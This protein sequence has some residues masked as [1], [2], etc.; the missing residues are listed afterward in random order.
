MRIAKTYKGG[1]A[2][3]EALESDIEI[4]PSW[5]T[6][7]LAHIRIEGSNGRWTDARLSAIRKRGRI[8]FVLSHEKGYPSE[9]KGQVTRSLT[10]NWIKKE[11]PK[12]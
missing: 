6:T 9:N 12:I 4:Y 3:V 8:R 2:F 1:P 10:A 7:A 11:P 5:Q